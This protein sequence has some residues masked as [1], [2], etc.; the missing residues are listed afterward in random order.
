MLSGVAAAAGVVAY[1]S[2]SELLMH[3]GM[4]SGDAAEF[5]D[6]ISDF[7]S[8]KSSLV[9]LVS[10]VIVIL[11]VI[12]VFK[13]RGRSLSAYSGMSHVSFWSIIGS[14]VL[15]IMLG[16][17]TYSL[18]PES[19]QETVA[20]ISSIALLCVVLGPFVEEF[21][22]RGILLKMFGASC[23]IVASVV[24]TSVLFAISHGEPVQMLYTFVLGIILAVV[25]IK[26]TS[27]WSVCMVHLAF[28]ISGALLAVGGFEL[29]GKGFAIS[30]FIVVVAMLIACSGGR[31]LES[32]K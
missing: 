32:A 27:L 9:L 13:L 3:G 24:I 17:I 26:S 20:E 2:L 22:F 21:M 10:Y 8:G 11:T 5:I 16:I 19:P 15:G 29:S 14:I 28:N 4:H 6:Y 23:G 7:V 25:R 18:I 1:Y 30:S 12:V 31:K